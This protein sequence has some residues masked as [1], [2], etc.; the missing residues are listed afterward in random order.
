MS[1]NKPALDPH[2]VAVHSSSAY[3]EPYRSRV[4]RDAADTA[5]YSDPEVDMLWSP[6]HA[7]GR[8][9]RRDGT[10]I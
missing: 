9:T 8:I 6:A 3:P 5:H 1:V 2:S 7:R 10:P 4:L